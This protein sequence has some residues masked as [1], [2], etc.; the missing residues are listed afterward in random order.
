[1]MPPFTVKETIVEWRKLRVVTA[2]AN[3]AN[4]LR[5]YH[6]FVVDCA[7]SPKSVTAVFA[8]AAGADIEHTRLVKQLTTGQRISK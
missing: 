7:G 8:T 2:K 3:D 5:P 6:V 4:L 1:M